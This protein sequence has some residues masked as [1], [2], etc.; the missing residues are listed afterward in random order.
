MNQCQF[1]GEKKL[2]QPWDFWTADVE[3]Q[4]C[5]SAENYIFTKLNFMQLFSFL[6]WKITSRV[7]L[8][9]VG[10]IIRNLMKK[11]TAE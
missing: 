5:A 4:K 6:N 8:W 9:E 11:Y 7:K 10:D 1:G 2:K 3:T